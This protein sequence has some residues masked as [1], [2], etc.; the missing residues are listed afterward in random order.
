MTLA[1]RSDLQAETPAGRWQRGRHCRPAAGADTLCSDTS[2]LLLVVRTLG[3]PVELD[4][5]AF[6]KRAA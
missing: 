4:S 6:G 5:T 2:E 1:R 3:D